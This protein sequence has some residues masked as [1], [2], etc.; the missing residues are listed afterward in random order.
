MFEQ[1][2]IMQREISFSS[3]LGL[4]RSKSDLFV[5]LLKILDSQNLAKL[6]EGCV[7]KLSDGGGG[8]MDV[9]V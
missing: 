4:K 7:A 3:L 6:G 8:E 2:A 1:V 5:K 9:R